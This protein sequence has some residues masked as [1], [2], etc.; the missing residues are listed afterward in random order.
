M[1]LELSRWAVSQSVSHLTQRSAG[2]GCEAPFPARNTTQFHDIE[3][4]ETDS[5]RLVTPTLAETRSR[6]TGGPADGERS[7]RPGQRDCACVFISPVSG[8]LNC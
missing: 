3:G 8:I 7:R 4:H 2:R 6:H 1:E 5:V